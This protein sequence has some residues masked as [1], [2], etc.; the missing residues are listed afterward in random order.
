MTD[1]KNKL[2]FCCRPDSWRLTT[3]AYCLDKMAKSPNCTFIFTFCQTL[4][5]PNPPC[6]NASVCQID[7]KQG[8]TQAHQYEIGG[9][10]ATLDPFSKTT[11]EAT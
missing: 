7:L 11:G 3:N 4:A 10:D 5:F 2:L 8:S 9:Y 6:N 1:D